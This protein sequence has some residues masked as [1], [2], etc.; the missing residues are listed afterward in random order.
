M[1]VLILIDYVNYR[2]GVNNLQVVKV[3]HGW[4]CLRVF[5]STVNKAERYAKSWC[6]KNDYKETK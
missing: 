4:N 1:N 5:T 6:K 2:G 3:V